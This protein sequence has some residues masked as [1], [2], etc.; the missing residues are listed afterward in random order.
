[1]KTCRLFTIEDLLRT[2]TTTISLHKSTLKKQQTHRSADGPREERQLVRQAGQDQGDQQQDVVQDEGH[3][4][5]R[6]HCPGLINQQSMRMN[7]QLFINPTEEFQHQHQDQWGNNLPDWFWS[8]EAST[9]SL[10]VCLSI[11]NHCWSIPDHWWSAAIT[12]HVQQRRYYKLPWCS[13]APQ[14]SE[15]EWTRLFY[16][17][18]SLSQ[19]MSFLIY[20]I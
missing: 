1:M 17:C 15:A 20:L 7:H 12:Q 9:Q 11:P 13:A 8:W 3:V 19:W 5:P 10:L 16:C 18:C 6:K 2:R 14:E 4:P